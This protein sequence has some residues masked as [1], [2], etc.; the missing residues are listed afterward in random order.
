MKA[1]FKFASA[2]SA[3]ALSAALAVPGAVAV[4]FVAVSAAEAAVVNR[5]EVR[6]NQRVDADTMRNYIAIKPG[7]SFSNSDIDDA[8]KALFGT[9]PVLGCPHQPGRL[10]PGG[11]GF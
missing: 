5:V 9:R 3:V 6:G 4:Q 2:A 1:A 10:D 8:V 11:S 7:K